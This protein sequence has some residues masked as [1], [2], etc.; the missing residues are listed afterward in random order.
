MAI[1]N[2]TKA[3][4]NK[5]IS[6]GFGN[7]ISGN[8]SGAIGE[9][10]TIS[11]SD[12]YSL[13]NNNTIG[14]NNAAFAIGNN[15]IIP[16]NLNGAIAMGDASTADASNP[17]PST[18]LNGINYYSFAGNAPVTD[19]VVSVGKAGAKRQLTYMAAGRL[20]DTS[21]DEVNGSKL[22]ATNT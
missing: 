8:G 3:T 17:T 18:L 15:I 7:R 12:S 22:F 2:S 14:A 16:P 4:G 5:S 20:S 10:S 1:G 9:P 19:S 11:D 21:T 13:G 6:I